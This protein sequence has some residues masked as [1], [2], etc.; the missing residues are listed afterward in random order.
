MRAAAAAASC[1]LPAAAAVGAQGASRRPQR[2][3]GGGGGESR[4]R[5]GPTQLIHCKKHVKK[6]CVCLHIIWGR[7][8]QL[9]L[10]SFEV[11]IRQNI[12]SK[13]SI[14]LVTQFSYQI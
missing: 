6:S 2:Q 7:R 8:V 12:E 3:A 5:G 14:F 1:Q 4:E 10:F 13:E 9:F 11:H